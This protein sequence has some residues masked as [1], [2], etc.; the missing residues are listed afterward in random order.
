M[1]KRMSIVKLISHNILSVDVQLNCNV[2]GCE[3]HPVSLGYL[4]YYCI[5]FRQKYKKGLIFY[6]YS[7]VDYRA[8]Y[9]A[10]QYMHRL[11]YFYFNPVI[12]I[13]ISICFV[14]EEY[15]PLRFEIQH[16]TCLVDFKILRVG[17]LVV[18]PAYRQYINLNLF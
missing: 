4:T 16:E 11:S 14:L 6:R 10:W 5:V 17:Y 13:Y 18:N 9:S 1:Q 8:S 3:M 2:P 12:L 15:I 7:S